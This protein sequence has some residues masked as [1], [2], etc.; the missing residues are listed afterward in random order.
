M[1]RN[2]APPSG[3][4]L[5]KN[6]SRS[7]MVGKDVGETVACTGAGGIGL[8]VVRVGSR[9][10]CGV[11]LGV[12]ACVGGIGFG[13]GVSCGGIKLGARSHVEALPVG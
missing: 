5:A 7:R 10:G 11:G 12:G 2:A 9:V 4:F 6:S 3:L 8:G 13:C 1:E